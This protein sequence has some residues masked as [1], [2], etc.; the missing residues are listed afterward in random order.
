M[1]N[2][3]KKINL[4]NKHSVFVMLKNNFKKSEIE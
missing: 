4:L 1:T 2:I 3:H